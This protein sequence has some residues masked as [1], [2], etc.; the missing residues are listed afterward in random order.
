VPP[1]VKRHGR[2]PSEL[3][4]GAAGGETSRTIPER[5]ARWPADHTDWVRFFP[6]TEGGF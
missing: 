4:G 5:V 2:F 6:E 3:R 1:V